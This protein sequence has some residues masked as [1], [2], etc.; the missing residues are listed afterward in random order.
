MARRLARMEEMVVRGKRSAAGA[1]AALLADYVAADG[2][3]G[4]RRA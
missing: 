2:L 4:G 3:A 1:A